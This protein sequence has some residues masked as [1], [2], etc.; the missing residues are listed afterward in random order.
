MFAITFFGSTLAATLSAV[1]FGLYLI[2]RRRFYW[3]AGMISSIVGGVL[4][5][6]LLKYVFHR[7]R[8]FFNDPC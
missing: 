6:R 1:P 4:L 5:N 8:P 2:W 3:L 7:P